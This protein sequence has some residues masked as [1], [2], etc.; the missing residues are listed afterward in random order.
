MRIKRILIPGLSCAILV[1][2]LLTFNSCQKE[3]VF[4]IHTENDISASGTFKVVDGRL[5]FSTVEDYE[6]TISELNNIGDAGFDSWEDEIGF[7]SLRRK[8]GKTVDYP[9]KDDLLG[10]LLNEDYEVVIEGKLFQLDYENNSVKVTDLSSE[11]KSSNLTKSIS[12][13]S[14]VL[15]VVF[16]GEEPEI[17]EVND[18]DQLKPKEGPFYW[19]TSAGPVKYKLCY[20]NVGIFRS[21]QAKIKQV[22]NI[23]KFSSVEIGYYAYNGWYKKKN[24]NGVIKI[25]EDDDAGTDRDLHYRPYWG[26][27]KLVQYDFKV[28]FSYDDKKTN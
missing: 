26:T 4:A 10:T 3:E 6:V 21:L 27:R 8:I 9:I 14:D 12:M 25:K 19:E 13:D 16:E 18:S 23:G 22:N 1:S 24:R 28:E 2:G 17:K 15:S 20:E 5:A 11:L 7:T